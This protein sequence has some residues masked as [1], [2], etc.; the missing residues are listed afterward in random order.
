MPQNALHPW[1]I[2]SHI[3]YGPQILALES[4]V[5]EQIKKI[6]N[7]VIF[8]H[9]KILLAAVMASQQTQVISSMTGATLC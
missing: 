3:S 6:I 7:M 2:S 5:S 1:Q 9:F 4:Y 8:I